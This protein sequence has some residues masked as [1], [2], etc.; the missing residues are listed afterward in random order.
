MNSLSSSDTRHLSPDLL[1]RI[2]WIHHVL[3][4]VESISLKKSIE[5]FRRDAHPADEVRI[6]QRIAA[7]YGLYVRRHPN[8]TRAA[9][10]AAYAVLVGLSLGVAEPDGT[11]SLDPVMR[12]ELTESFRLVTG[13]IQ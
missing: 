5:S 2:E 8:A 7:A 9:K 12:A 13:A 4:E 1:K 6:W 11:D 3:H 10:R